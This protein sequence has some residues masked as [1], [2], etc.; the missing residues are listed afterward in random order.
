MVVFGEF[1][2]EC[3]N[4]NNQDYKII[5]VL[6]RFETENVFHSVS[7]EFMSSERL[8]KAFRSGL[9]KGWV[10]DDVID[11]TRRVPNETVIRDGLSYV[12]F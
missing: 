8:I 6:I 5:T 1:S 10:I 12:I 11:F 7:A 2:T 4:E 3:E 9:S